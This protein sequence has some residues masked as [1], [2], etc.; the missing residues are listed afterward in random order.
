[1]TPRKS[2]RNEPKP[3]GPLETE[4]WL[5]EAT[6]SSATLQ[7]KACGGQVITFI[8]ERDKLRDGERFLAVRARFPN[9]LS[10]RRYI[11]TIRS[12]AYGIGRCDGAY[13]YDAS[14]TKEE[15]CARL[16]AD[17]TVVEIVNGSNG[18]VYVRFKF[19]EFTFTWVDTSDDEP[20][21]DDDTDEPEKDYA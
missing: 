1:M 9:Y 19:A 3:D 18:I 16:D 13:E 12:D 2:Y 6:D 10:F 20:A 8:D 5:V 15:M 4:V 11:D 7:V 17:D 21:N 14:E